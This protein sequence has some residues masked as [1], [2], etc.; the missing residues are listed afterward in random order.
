MGFPAPDRLEAAFEALGDLNRFRD[1][2][3]IEAVASVL[4]SAGFSDV[5]SWARSA[6]LPFMATLSL[7]CQSGQA[8]Q[9][10]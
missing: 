7:V 10:D 9:E 8:P 6:P 2:Q 5:A 1:I 4:D 3:G